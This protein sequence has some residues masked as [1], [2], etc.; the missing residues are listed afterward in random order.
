MSVCGSMMC[1][2]ILIAIACLTV[3]S[4]CAACLPGSKLDEGMVE[5][6]AS[7]QAVPVADAPTAH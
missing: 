7:A 5:K 4:G 3:L 6:T 2:R 1:S